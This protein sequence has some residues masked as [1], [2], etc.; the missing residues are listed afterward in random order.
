MNR[1]PCMHISKEMAARMKPAHVRAIKEGRGTGRGKDYIP[2]LHTDKILRFGHRTVSPSTKFSRSD[3]V[4][5]NI[6]DSLGLLLDYSPVVSDYLPQFPLDINIT[7]K[8]AEMYGWNHPADDDGKLTVMTTDFKIFMM[9]GSV[10]IR[11]VKDKR[12]LGNVGKLKKLWIERTYFFGQG[13]QN[14]KIVTPGEI[15]KIRVE[16]I[17]TLR[18][19]LRI[20]DFGISAT[21]VDQVRNFC[22]RN[23]TEYGSLSDC[24]SACDRHLGFKKEEAISLAVAK[25]LIAKREWYWD[26]KVPFDPTEPGLHRQIVR[27]LKART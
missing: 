8:I 20:E 22:E 27:K 2:F 26:M 12:A 6:E 1:E 24:A 13:I 23:L 4:L 11:T 3:D 16:N 18:T 5:S 21:Q 14:W 25:H 15:N 19:N 9:D 10:L 17:I 7:T